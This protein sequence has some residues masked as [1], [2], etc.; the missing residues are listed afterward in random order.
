[1]LGGRLDGW[2]TLPKGH[3][4]ISFGGCLGL[5]TCFVTEKVGSRRAMETTAGEEW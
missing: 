3:A 2:E 5:T 1:M 4:L